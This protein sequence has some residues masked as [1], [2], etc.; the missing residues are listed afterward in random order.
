M[1]TWTGYFLPKVMTITVWN[2]IGSKGPLASS[3]SSGSLLAEM[4]ISD[5]KFYRLQSMQWV[6]TKLL[7]IPSC[8]WKVRKIDGASLLETLISDTAFLSNLCTWVMIVLHCE[9]VLTIEI[10][11][12][13]SRPFNSWPSA[14]WETRWVTDQ[15]GGNLTGSNWLIHEVSWSLNNKK[16][17]ILTAYCQS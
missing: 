17:S 14:Q 16:N 4:Q 5:V 11:I 9:K 3:F 6:P 7:P 2:L 15:D 13:H 8:Q 1:V 10:L 12:F